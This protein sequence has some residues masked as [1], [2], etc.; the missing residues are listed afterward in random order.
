MATRGRPRALDDAKRREICAL[1]SAGAG[2]KTAARYAGCSRSTVYKEA[3]ENEEFRER[4]ERAKS[5]ACLTPLQALRQAYQEDWR[6]A[7]WMLER[8]DPNRFGR[9][10]RRAVGRR[11]LHALT[12]DLIAIVRDEVDHPVHRERAIARMRAA[13]NYALHHAWDTHRSG[14]SLDRAMQYFENRNP[15]QEAWAEFDFEPDFQSPKH[16][17]AA[18]DS[19]RFRTPDDAE[20]RK[21]RRLDELLEEIPSSFQGSSDDGAA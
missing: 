13:L 12:R 19:D 9:S 4:L 1:V 15:D 5:T 16:L 10:Y 3:S 18:A 17:T 6:A 14:K 11:E 2:I 21:G 8:T 20:F 7:A